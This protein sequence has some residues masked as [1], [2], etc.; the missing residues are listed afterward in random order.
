MASNNSPC[1]RDGGALHTWVGASQP[2]EQT[3]EM[4]LPLPAGPPTALAV[5]DAAEELAVMIE[6]GDHFT[7]DVEQSI[8]VLTRAVQDLQTKRNDL[9]TFLTLL[10][11]GGANSVLIENVRDGLR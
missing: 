2:V 8:T 11:R 9:L 7:Q 3:A 10:E 1:P 6:M 4:L 5:Q